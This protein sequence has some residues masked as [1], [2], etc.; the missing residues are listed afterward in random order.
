MS[1]RVPLPDPVRMR[2]FVAVEV[3]APELPVP[4]P[5]PPERHLTLRFFAD[6]P[7]ER[8]DAVVAALRR[9]S[10]GLGPFEVEL[11]SGGAFPDSARPRVVYLAVGVGSTE[12]SRLAGRFEELCRGEGFPAEVRPFVPHVTLFRVRDPAEAVRAREVLGALEGRGFGRFRVR[13]LK[14]FSSRLSRDG[15]EH[16][17]VASVALEPERSVHLPAVPTS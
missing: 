17:L 6:L 14:L 15:A 5:R 1:R 11:R 4:V 8:V 10:E 3:P 2:A 13:E 9:S 16:T 12:L 7:A